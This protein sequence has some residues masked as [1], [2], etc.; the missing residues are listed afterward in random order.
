MTSRPKL[1]DL[2]HLNEKKKNEIGTIFQLFI[3]WFECLR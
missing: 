1:I 3:V 2:F